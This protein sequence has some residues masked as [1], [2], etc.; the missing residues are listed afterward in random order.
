MLSIIVPVYNTSKY[1]KKCINSILQQSYNNYELILIDDGSTDGSG[2]ICDE[3]EKIDT[4]VRVIHQLNKGLPLSRYVGIEMAYGEYITFIDSDD[5]IGEKYLETLMNAFDYHNI[6]ISIG[7]F[8]ECKEDDKRNGINSGVN[9]CLFD[10]KEALKHLIS[11]DIFSWNVC[12]KIY[13]AGI[14][15]QLEP[16]WYV[17]GM[18]EDLEFT[19]KIFKKVK[20]VH[21]IDVRGYYWR[22]REDSM[23]RIRSLVG[24]G[25][26]FGRFKHII[27]DSEVLGDEMFQCALQNALAHLSPMFVHGIIH[28][29]IPAEVAIQYQLDLVRWSSC[30]V[31]HSMINNT[32]TYYLFSKPVDEVQNQYDYIKLE[33]DIKKF[34]EMYRNIY[35]YGAG[36]MGKKVSAFLDEKQIQYDGFVVTSK[37]DM[38]DDNI[39]CIDDVMKNSL[40]DVGFIVALARKNEV[41]VEK[42]LHTLGIENF[43]SVGSYFFGYLPIGQ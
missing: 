23:S 14:L 16:W 37:E 5:W 9:M 21:F 36:S 20:C 11:F 12:G 42:Y 18:G 24:Y 41:V 15:Q 34:R 19:W 22:Y 1:L 39:F 40:S 10:T 26:L 32:Y 30:L 25:V 6:D 8:V 29:W 17:E 7:A 31:D 13:K 28:R 3:F 2:E 35:I 33:N 27:D 38:L 43:I 4:R